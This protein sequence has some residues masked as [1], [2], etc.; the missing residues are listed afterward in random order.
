MSLTGSEWP[1]GFSPSRDSRLYDRLPKA[2][3]KKTS[4]GTNLASLASLY[5]L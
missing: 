2:N 3:S 5:K 1:A 4:F